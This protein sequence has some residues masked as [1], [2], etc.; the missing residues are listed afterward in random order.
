MSLLRVS[1]SSLARVSK[2]PTFA[3]ATRGYADGPTNKAGATASSQGW[4]KREQAQEN[5]YVQQAEK[6][7][8]QKLRESIKKQREHLDEVESQL[9]NLDKK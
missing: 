4:N 2:A 5:Q 1:T 3:M 7:K 6:E 8:L 9:N